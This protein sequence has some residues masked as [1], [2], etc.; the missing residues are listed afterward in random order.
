MTRSGEQHSHQESSA[1]TKLEPEQWG[2]AS[3][4]AKLVKERTRRWAWTELTEPEALTWA[5]PQERRW[6]SM[7]R[8]RLAAAEA[9]GRR[10]LTARVDCDQHQR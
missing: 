9:Q 5:E 3:R 2:L 8:Q 10:T 1:A 6:C 7:A 4:E